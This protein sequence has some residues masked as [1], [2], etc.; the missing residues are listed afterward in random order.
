MKSLQSLLK[1]T[2]KVSSRTILGVPFYCVDNERINKQNQFLLSG[3]NFDEGFYRGYFTFVNPLDGQNIEGTPETY[4]RLRLVS[5]LVIQLENDKKMDGNT[6]IDLGCGNLNV[7]RSI[8]SRFDHEVA[9]VNCD[10]SGPWSSGVK[11]SLEQGTET[12][13]KGNRKLDFINVQYDF[14]NSKWPFQENK[15][16]FVTTCMVLH[17]IKPELKA[18]LM[19]DLYATLTVGG[20]LVVVDVFKKDDSGFKVTQAGERG[21]GGSEGHIMTITDF[22]KLAV[23]VGFEVDDIATKLLDEARNYQ[24]EDELQRALNNGSLT[25]AINKAAWFLVLSKPLK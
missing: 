16:D 13:L 18:G 15:V 21:P 1:G 24:N 7:A 8:P 3:Y 14:N 2:D 23:E 22:I 4:G 17:H 10:I 12:I 11:S 19:R 6:L 5:Y 25:L 20:K 9:V